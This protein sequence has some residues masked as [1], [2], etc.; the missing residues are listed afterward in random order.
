MKLLPLFLVAT[1][2]AAI[3]SLDTC[4][5]QL[6]I[7]EFVAANSNGLLDED[8][9]SSDWIE[10]FNAGDEAVDLQGW[11]LTDR[12]D[13]LT[14]WTFPE[15]ILEAGD[16]VTVFASGKDRAD[17][18]RQLHTDFQLDAGGEYL[19]LVH[20]DGA[21]I[22]TQFGPN[23]TPYPEQFED[24]SFGVGMQEISLVT[25]GNDVSVLIPQDGSLDSTW[26]GGNEDTFVEDDHWFSGT[27]A[28]GY[29]AEIG[30]QAD[31]AS[32]PT[33]DLRV[34]LRA[35]AI[36]GLSDGDPVAAWTDQ[37]GNT[38]NAAQVA[39]GNRPTYQTSGL[40][41]LP[42]VRFDGVD[43]HFLIAS[44]A[45]LEP[46][47]LSIFA[48]VVPTTPGHSNGRDVFVKNH[49][50][51]PPYASYGI[52][53]VGGDRW[54]MVSSHNG[55]FTPRPG[56]ATTLGQPDLL[57]GVWNAGPN[58]TLH[59]D[60]AQTMTS[61]VTGSIAYNGEPIS[62]GTWLGDLANNSF[63]GDIAEILFYDTALSTDD[64]QLV[65]GHLGW[66]YGLQEQ[67]PSDHPYRFA[68]PIPEPSTLAIAAIGLLGLTGIRRRRDR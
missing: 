2:A 24:I 34:W 1:F 67:L 55:I 46:Q 60:G 18:P 14:K 15:V 31:I 17:S 65:E 30:Q 47:A 28:V 66:K 40:N 54:Q 49:T 61:N 3:S 52:D 58:M 12:A 48:V 57:S 32:I 56:S 5:A 20:P 37:S 22:A 19:A 35:D 53:L 39:S 64:R 16:Y 26:T 8:G 27:T 68:N 62:V 29:D 23:G 43:D 38:N 25:T 33:A 6:L 21:T 63:G 9:D 45:G 44:N 10:I 13:N 11:H 36:T 50:R 51:A 42:T 41:G 59:V 4:Q 7:S